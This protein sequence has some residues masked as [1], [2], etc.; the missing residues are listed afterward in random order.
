MVLGLLHP[1]SAGNSE[2]V[3]DLESQ[4]NCAVLDLG[5]CGK[6]MYLELVCVGILM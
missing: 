5:H 4:D 3:R 1:E 2:M 6:S